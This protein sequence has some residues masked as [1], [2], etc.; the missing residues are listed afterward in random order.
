MGEGIIGT[1]MTKKMGCGRKGH[2]YHPIGIVENWKK[3]VLI[4]LAAMEVNQLRWP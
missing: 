3:G 1:T 2:D 4:L